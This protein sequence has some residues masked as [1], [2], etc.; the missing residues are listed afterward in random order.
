M[1]VIKFLK[2]PHKN[3]NDDVRT[4]IESKKR[5]AQYSIVV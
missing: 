5:D 4:K 2:E 1:P 3:V